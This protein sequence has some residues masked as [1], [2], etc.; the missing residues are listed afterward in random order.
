MGRWHAA[1]KGKE[2]SRGSREEN[3]PRRV[4]AE[5]DHGRSVEKSIW[6]VNDSFLRILQIC[7]RLRRARLLVAQARLRQ[8]HLVSTVSRQEVILPEAA[9]DELEIAVT[10]LGFVGAMIMGRTEGQ[11]LRDD[12]F[13]PIVGRAEAL[14]VPIC[15]H[16]GVPPLASTTANYAGLDPLVTARFQTP[17]WGWHVETGIHF[18]H[19]FLLGVFDRYPGLRIILG[20]WGE[21]VPLS[22]D[23][24]DQGFPRAIVGL[25]RSFSDYVRSNVYITPSGT[26][27][28]EQLQYCRNFLGAH[29]IM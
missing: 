20:H 10:H 8:W 29:R 17:A 12:K 18:I 15:L 14:E 2:E 3:Q 19:P 28:Q 5:C 25:D 22:L 21:M 23:R 6:Y 9:A 4:S 27:S 13:E 1:E 16:P 26:F 11:F 7:H 24:L